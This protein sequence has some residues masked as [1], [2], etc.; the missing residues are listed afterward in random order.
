MIKNFALGAELNSMKL[1]IFNIQTYQLFGVIVVG[2]TLCLREKKRK[3]K[4]IDLNE[5]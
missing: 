3:K 4:E 5:F 1:S 2:G